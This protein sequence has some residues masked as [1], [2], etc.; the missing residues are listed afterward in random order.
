MQK[1]IYLIRNTQNDKQYVGQTKDLSERMRYHTIDKER[2][3]YGSPLYEDMRV[4]GEH[5]FLIQ[6][7]EVVG[8]DDADERERY[9]IEHFN[10]VHPNGYNLTTGGELG[11]SYSD[12]TKER[13][14]KKTKE[15]WDDPEIAARMVDGLRKSGKA[16]LGKIKVPRV[17]RQCSVCQSNFNTLTSSSQVYCSQSCAGKT[18]IKLATEAYVKKRDDLKLEIKE[19]SINWALSNRDVIQKA[20]YNRISTCLAPLTEEIYNRY[21]VKDYRIISKAI[22]GKESRKEMMKF[23]K[24]IVND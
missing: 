14:G 21:D 15:R 9:W 22:C 18:A 12:I 24:Q 20:P 1:T 6:E 4:Y 10:T 19:F 13:I 2:N 7:L 5:N 3:R 16:Q 11:K 17:V 8:D 23:L